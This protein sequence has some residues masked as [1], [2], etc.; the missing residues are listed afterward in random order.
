MKISEIDKNAWLLYFLPV[1]IGIFVAF[2]TSLILHH[3]VFN[4]NYHLSND[5]A[6]ITIAFWVEIVARPIVA[7]ISGVI[8]LGVISRHFKKTAKI[9]S[10]KKRNVGIVLLLTLL[11]NLILTI[12]QLYFGLYG[13]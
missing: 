13:F 5:M 9:F 12:V 4:F 1:C 8:A 2:L 6:G 7:G 10:L 11:G 3:T